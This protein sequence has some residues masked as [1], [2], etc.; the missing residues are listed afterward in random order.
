M[1]PNK[2][3]QYGPAGP[4]ANTAVRFRRHCGKRY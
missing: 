4:D 1:V 3:G 2:I